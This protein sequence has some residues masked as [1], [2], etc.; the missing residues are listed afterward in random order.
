MP[1]NVAG[2]S[3]AVAIGDEV[4]FAHGFGMRET[5][6]T[7]PVMP[8]IFVHASSVSKAV[9]AVSVLRLV[10]ERVL[11]LDLHRALSGQAGTLLGM[12]TM[13]L[14]LTPE[15]KAGDRGKLG[16]GMFTE[17][18]RSSKRFGHTVDNEGYTAREVSVLEEGREPTGLWQ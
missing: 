10:Q 7:E 9:S 1:Q 3:L 12:E 5:G 18:G 16:L 8:T 6:T 15:A 13:Q 17:D 14:M 2:L 11:G 4:A